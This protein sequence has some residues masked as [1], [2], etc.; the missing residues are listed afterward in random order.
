MRIQKGDRFQATYSKQS[1][2]IVGKW[3]GNLVLAPT[4]KDNDECLIYSVG[5]IEELVNTLKWVR[6]A[7]CEQ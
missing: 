4:A 5:E 6:E 3:G 1:Y 2:V 7:G